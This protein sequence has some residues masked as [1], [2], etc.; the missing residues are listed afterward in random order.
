M[1]R[2]RGGGRRAEGAPAAGGPPRVAGVVGPC[3]VE[4]IHRSAALALVGLLAVGP[5]AVGALHL[6]EDAQAGKPLDVEKLQEVKVGVPN[7][8]LLQEIPELVKWVPP[9]AALLAKARAGAPAGRSSPP[10]P[11]YR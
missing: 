9:R 11:T 5:R 10:P 6:G 3:A 1:R 2:R 7:V 8:V 4:D